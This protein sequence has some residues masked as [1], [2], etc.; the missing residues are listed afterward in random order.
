M[1]NQENI[2]LDIDMYV[3]PYITL[4]ALSKV[5]KTTKIM[6]EKN[7]V[8]GDWEESREVVTEIAV[9]KE[10]QNNGTLWAHFYVALAGQQ[11]DPTQKDYNPE[12]A[13]HFV[14][15]LNQYL[16]KKKVKKLRNLLESTEEPAPVEPAPKK[17]EFGSF[18]HPNV[19]LSVI[20]NSGVLNYR[21]MHPG[22]RQF[23][24][25]ERTSARDASGQNGWYYPIIFV[26]KFW[27][28]R[29]HMT[30]LN[31]TVTTLPLRISLNNLSNWKF[32]L[33]ASVDENMKQTQRQAALGGPMP[34]G[35]DGTE[36]EMFKEILLDTNSYLLATTG[37]VSILHM[38]FEMLAFKNDI[39]SRFIATSLFPACHFLPN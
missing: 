29:N 9:P 28:L 3:S 32:S 37:I 33:Y 16:P 18:Y 34:A 17:V 27:Q 6:E 11:L 7:F 36:F 26:N 20:P 15:P 14:W 30:E 13:Y 21:T 22:V 39:V 5:P 31:S 12:T 25:L 10:V 8:V 23:I 19:T 24:Q 2:A 4:P 38:V 1:W 35:S